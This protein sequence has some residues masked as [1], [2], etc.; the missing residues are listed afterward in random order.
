MKLPSKKK[1]GDEIKAQDFNDLVDYVR[2]ITPI[3]DQCTIKT[4]QSKFG[5]CLSGYGTGGGTNLVMCRLIE[6]EI[7][8][9]DANGPDYDLG[10]CYRG[11]IY[12]NGIYT[13]ATETDVPIYIPIIGVDDEPGW[14]DTNFAYF[15][16]WEQYWGDYSDETTT[17]QTVW[18]CQPEVWR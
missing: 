2:M 14:L 17:Q 3:G 5:T 12:E 18:T 13:D 6:K 7:D 4:M 9:T 1:I 11:N 8:R 10:R 16:C 15:P